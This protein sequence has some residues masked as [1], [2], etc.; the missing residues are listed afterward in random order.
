MTRRG[1]CVASIL[2][3]LPRC[4]AQRGAT[5][6][7]RPSDVLQESW[8]A[9]LKRFVQ[10]DGRVIDHHAEGISTSEGQAYA[11]LRAV[12]I[13]DRPSF[14]KT[15]KWALD[16][17][18]TRVRTDRL[19]A[20]KW[21]KAPDGKW[22]VLDKAFATDADEDAALALILA[23][24]QWGDDRYLSAARGVLADLWKLATR[25]VADRRYLLA[26]DTLCD[27]RSCRLN[28]S[29]CAPYAY[30][31]FA[32]HDRLHSWDELVT[33]SY[34]FLNDVSAL[35]ETHLPPDWVRID[36]EHGAISLAD[37][38]ASL[39][40]YDAFRT[41][42]RVALD[43]RLFA[44]SRAEEYLRMAASWLEREWRAKQK[45]P[46]AITPAGKQ[47][48][49]YESLEMLATTAAASRSS[50]PEIAEAMRARV[51]SQYSKGLWGNPPRYYA[52]NWVWFAEALYEGFLGPLAKVAR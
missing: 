34:A 29:Y 4:G 24:Q 43:H 42:W 41:F 40:S 47:A 11:M 16:N 10:S 26:G 8:Q 5:A 44:D 31:I 18:N 37:P 17:L 51:Q 21:G 7:Q 1:W 35:T 23:H 28:P 46:A 14:D 6:D 38:K 33:S 32:R 9:Y 25:T 36:L 50:A 12:W 22:T 2:A 30:R 48:A 39:F 3:G 15:W 45:L 13:D 52:Q 20:W 49:Q 19:W 27:G